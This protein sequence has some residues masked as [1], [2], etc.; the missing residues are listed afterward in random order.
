[1]TGDYPQFAKSYAHEQLVEY[2]L[3]SEADQQ[4]IAQFRGNI[5]RTSVTILLKSLQYTSFSVSD[6]RFLNR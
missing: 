5:N 1:M 6:T 4:F 3:V 2:F